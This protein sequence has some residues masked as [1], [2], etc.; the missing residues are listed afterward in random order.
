M[1]TEDDKPP[2]TAP[3]IPIVCDDCPFIGTEE[4]IT[5]EELDLE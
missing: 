2:C 1:T 5:E 3:C 4:D